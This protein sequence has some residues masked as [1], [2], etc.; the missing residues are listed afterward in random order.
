MAT[1]KKLKSG[2]WRVQLYIGKGP[3]GKPRYHSI[4][5][6]S[7]KQAEFD[8]LQLQLHYKEINRDSGNMTLNEAMEKYM[9]SKDGVLSPSTLRGY[10]IIRRTSL[11]GL[12]PRKLNEL[13][14]P[15]VQQAFNQEAKAGKSPKTLRNIYGL[16]S[17]TLRAYLPEASLPVTLPQPER[18]EQHILEPDQIAVLLQA[19]KGD[20]MELPVLLA[21]WLSLRSSEVTGLT[22][23]CVD[24]KHNTISIRQARVRN[25]E[26]EWV[27][28]GTKTTSSTRTLHAP[29]Y[30]MER[31]KKAK[32][33]AESDR[34]VTIPG[35]C[36]YQRLRTILRRNGL[37][38]IRFHD[39]RHTAASVMLALNIPDKYAQQR[40]GWAS[41]STLKRVY[42][43]TMVQQRATVD[44]TID[45]FY[46]TL[47][48]EK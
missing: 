23:D 14:Q 12:M 13:T 2:S 38:E 6:A 17:A 43:H 16:F 21:V 31:L 39:L 33:S 41:N 27:V 11:P 8:A 40:G 42:Q 32:A 47:L 7:K 36:L 30:I 20:E 35:N 37:P 1:A 44:K 19:V 48:S 25:A 15:M 46:E 18:K 29:A 5:R 4:T 28:K 34:V 22:W 9:E 10:N 26:N 24:F 45:Q 3:D